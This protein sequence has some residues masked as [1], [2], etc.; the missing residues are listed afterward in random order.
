MDGKTLNHVK[1]V[2]FQLAR[3]NAAFPKISPLQKFKGAER[4]IL[5][6][7]T[8]QAQFSTLLSRSTTVTM[9]LAMQRSLH[10]QR[11]HSE[12]NIFTEREISPVLINLWQTR[13]TWEMLPNFTGRDFSNIWL[14]CVIAFHFPAWCFYSLTPK[15]L[16]LSKVSTCAFMGT[17]AGTSSLNHTKQMDWDAVHQLSA[18]PQEWFSD[19]Q[20]IPW[21]LIIQGWIPKPPE[22]H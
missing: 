5:T 11:T 12:L 8:D 17:L 3:K 18:P 13:Q 21:H 7:K 15:V 6:L 10:E 9:T 4:E 14:L 2:N 16:S 22:Q 1:Q 19:L 20:S